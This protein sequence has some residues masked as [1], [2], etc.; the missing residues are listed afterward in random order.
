MMMGLKPAQVLSLRCLGWTASPCLWPSTPGCYTGLRVLMKRRKVELCGP[1][2]L[3][4]QRL[5]L[6][7]S[8]LRAS[9]LAHSML[10]A[11]QERDCLPDLD[12]PFLSE[13]AQQVQ[14]MSATRSC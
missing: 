11:F 1:P 10:E 6:V 5:S 8:T 14:L 9:D 4:G 13:A 7:Q 2:A 3:F 12:D